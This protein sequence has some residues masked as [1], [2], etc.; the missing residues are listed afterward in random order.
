MITFIKLL[1]KKDRCVLTFGLD[2]RLVTDTF[3]DGAKRFVDVF[4]E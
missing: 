2:I 1:I 4:M 3:R